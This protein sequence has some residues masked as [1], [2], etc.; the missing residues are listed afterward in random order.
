MFDI[1]NFDFLISPKNLLIEIVCNEL[2]F[3]CFNYKIFPFNEF[4]KLKNKRFKY[5]G[6][7]F[8]KKFGK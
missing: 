7:N 4:W 6:K 3:V 1:T 5:L 8:L 2:K